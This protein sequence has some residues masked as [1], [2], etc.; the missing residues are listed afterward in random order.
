MSDAELVAQKPFRVL[1]ILS[2][3][4]IVLNCGS[5]DG[6][7]KGWEFRV[8][9]YGNE[10]NDP[11][12]GE[13]LGRV[14]IPRGYGKVVVLQKRLCTIESTVRPQSSLAIFAYQLETA[15]LPFAG[16]QRGD[17]ADLITAK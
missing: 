12:S 4:R 8:Y 14:Y 5:S 6:I 13:N 9:A 10:L 16:A 1:D 15:I 11:D 3:S 17:Y 2:P 7:E